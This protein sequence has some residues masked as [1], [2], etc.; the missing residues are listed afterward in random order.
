MGNGTQTSSLKEIWL[1]ECALKLNSQDYSQLQS[2]LMPQLLQWVFGTGCYG[3][4]S[5]RG[6]GN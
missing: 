3:T 2:I 5:S 1:G 6:G 4:G